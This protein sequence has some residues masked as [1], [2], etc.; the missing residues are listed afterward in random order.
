ML[1]IAMDIKLLPKQLLPTLLKKYG[2]PKLWK[3]NIIN[4][5]HKISNENGHIY[6]DIHGYINVSCNSEDSSSLLFSVYLSEHYS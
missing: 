5:W 4:C 2:T 3:H 6:N 1:K